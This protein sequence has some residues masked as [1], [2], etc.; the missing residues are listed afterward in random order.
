MNIILW[1]K[2][3][4]MKLIYEIIEKCGNEEFASFEEIFNKDFVYANPETGGDL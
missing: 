3:S 4:Q 1:M 2:A